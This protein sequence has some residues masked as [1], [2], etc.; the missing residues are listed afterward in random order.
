MKKT[1]KLSY[2]GKK[3]DRTFIIYNLDGQSTIG[4]MWSVLESSKNYDEILKSFNSE[5]YSQ[6]K[7]YNEC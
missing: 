1:I 2:Q 6:Y 5:K 4:A 7:K 3:E